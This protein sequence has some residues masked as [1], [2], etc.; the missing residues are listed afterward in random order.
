MSGCIDCGKKLGF[1]DSTIGGRCMDCH[2][3][4]M[5]KTLK[6]SDADIKAARDKEENERKAVEASIRTVMVTTEMQPDIGIKHRLGIVTAEVA[7]GMNAF[8]DLFATVRNIVGGR[9]EA[10]QKTM[11]DS[12][13]TVLFELKKEAHAL[14]ADAVI[15]VDLDYVQIGDTGWGMILV[16]ATGTAVVTSEKTSPR[17]G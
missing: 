8:K 15:A 5:A 16:V 14:G 17:D 9:S 3:A 6:M 13:D 11:R 12:R 1:F 2:S 7:Y 10:I 4:H